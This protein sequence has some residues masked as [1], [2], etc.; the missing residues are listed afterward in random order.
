M[1]NNTYSEVTTVTSSAKDTWGGCETQKP[2][3]TNIGLFP[4]SSVCTILG[5]Q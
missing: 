2:E 3:L 4:Q 1:N 5:L